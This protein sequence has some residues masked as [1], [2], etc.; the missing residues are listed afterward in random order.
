M[1]HGSPRV[2]VIIPAFNAE[3]T[4]SQALQSLAGQS[5]VDWEAIVV[6]DGSTDATFDLAQRHAMHDPRIRAM[7]QVNAGASA[8]RNAG[9]A[10][11]RAEW[12]VFLDSDDWLAR[13]HLVRLSE[14]LDTHGASIAFGGYA[15]VRPDGGT[16]A[17]ES[18]AGIA[19]RPFDVFAQRSAAAI[20]CF[21]LRRDLVLGVGGFDT[22]L[23]TCEDWD[24]WQRVAR[25]GARFIAVPAVLA[26]VRVRQDSLSNDRRWMIR[27]AVEVISRAQ[28]AD[29]DESAALFAIWCAAAEAGRGRD[30]SSL[31]DE[32]TRL[33]DLRSRVDDVCASIYQGMVTGG[34][35]LRKE[36]PE[37]WPRISQHLASTLARIEEASTSRG[38]AYQL[39]S[40]LERR[41]LADQEM[42][43]PIALTTWIGIRADLRQ[44]LTTIVP[45]PGIDAVHCRVCAGNLLLATIDF[46]TFGTIDAAARARTIVEALGWRA[47][48][49]HGQLLRRS[50]FWRALLVDGVSTAPALG[51]AVASRLT[52]HRTGIR[53]R[54]GDVLRA[55]VRSALVAAEP[56]P[57]V[58]SS[59]S[60][61]ERIVAE[62]RA[63]ASALCASPAVVS[64]VPPQ[65]TGQTGQSAGRGAFWEECYQVPDPWRY[66]SAYEQRKYSTDLV[67][68]RRGSD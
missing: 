49:R 9:I 40:A 42:R 20:N 56:S 41:I 14:A 35:L 53:A 1:S 45:P 22:S 58:V 48:V 21:M 29:G 19:D 26:Y 44:P 28:R 31:L 5:L 54:V 32:L 57:S 6:D 67:P 61:V 50:R 68:A 25:T 51:R 39:R 62:E 11:A 59:Q 37:A 66:E 47:T 63:A 17:V 55:A 34:Q 33:P 30:G 23:R 65:R 64:A 15:L 16:I 52:G 3:A 38:I 18:C 13:D 7:R 27:D 60:R 46:P 43:Q 12:L 2:S 36:I 24:L 8:A 10:H 4:L